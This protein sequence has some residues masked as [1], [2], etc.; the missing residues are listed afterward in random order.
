MAVIN[1]GYG[2]GLHRQCSNGL[3]VYLAGEKAPV[4]GRVC[5]DVCMVD[6]TGLSEVKPG[7]EVEIYGPHVPIEDAAG[8]AGTIQY[9]LLCALTPRV[10]RHYIG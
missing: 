4:V 9:E 1:I 8:L 6:I 7:D 5:M 10:K 2:D 3:Q